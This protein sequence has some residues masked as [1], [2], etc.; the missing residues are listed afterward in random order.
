[1]LVPEEYGGV[2]RSISRTRRHES[3]A[4]RRGHGRHRIGAVDDLFGDPEDGRTAEGAL[5]AALAT[6][7][8]IAGFALTESDAGSEP[9][10]SRDRQRNGVG[11]VLNGRK[12]WCTS[13]SYAGVIMGMFRTGAA[14]AKGVSAFLFEP[15]R[16]HKLERVT[17]KL[18]IHTSNTCDLAF[19]DVHVEQDALLARSRG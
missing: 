14:G 8:V 11:Y 19:D 2:G 17:E 9:R 12:Q 1:M 7:D 13:G 5:A 3:G 4:G 10:H 18:G 15:R 6:A 16:R